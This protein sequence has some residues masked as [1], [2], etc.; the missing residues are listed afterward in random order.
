MFWKYRDQPLKTDYTLKT[1]EFIF[2][3]ADYLD[4]Q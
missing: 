2:L 3:N 1:T 4:L